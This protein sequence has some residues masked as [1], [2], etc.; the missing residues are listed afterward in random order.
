MALFLYV[1]RNGASFQIFNTHI[2][3]GEE[4]G[5]AQTRELLRESPKNFPT[6]L[7][8]DFNATPESAIVREIEAAGFKD[9]FAPDA[10]TAVANSRAKKIDYIFASR[11]IVA[12]A[13][14]LP[15]LEDTTA[16]PSASEP[17]DHLVLVADLEPAPRP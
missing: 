4:Q 13:R 12:R 5:L 3:W 2:K 6:V 17:S 9:P 16:L 15:S 14:P 10:F 7:C 8:G 1:L 11:H